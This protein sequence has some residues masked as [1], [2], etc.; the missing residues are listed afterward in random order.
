MAGPGWTWHGRGADWYGL[1]WTWHVRW[2]FG[3]IWRARSHASPMLFSLCLPSPF[4]PFAFDQSIA[5][6]RVRL[7]EH[8]DNMRACINYYYH[9][10]T[11]TLRARC[12]IINA[13]VTDCLAQL[14]VF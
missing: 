11:P 1:V 2:L 5:M 4:K 13:L 7:W 12:L 14:A 8:N 9:I 6:Y 3:M 10:R